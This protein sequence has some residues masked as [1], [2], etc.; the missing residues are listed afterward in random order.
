MRVLMMSALLIPMTIGCGEEHNDKT[1]A[2]ADTE[3]HTDCE[4]STVR[5][6]VTDASDWDIQN[7]QTGNIQPYARVMAEDET[8]FNF[9]TVADA[10]G[11]YEIELD[12]GTWRLSAGPD[13]SCF[14]DEVEIDLECEPAVVHL[15]V[16]SCMGR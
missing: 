16:I 6:T 8:G 13:T 15:S 12:T 5:G 9:E 2:D 4:T 1:L 3:A 10:D 14:G 11:S 7:G